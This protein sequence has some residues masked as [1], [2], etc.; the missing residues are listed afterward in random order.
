MRAFVYEYPEADLCMRMAKLWHRWVETKGLE[1]PRG[2]QGT[3][4]HIRE[5]VSIMPRIEEANTDYIAILLTPSPPPPLG[6]MP[7]PPAMGTT[8]S[9]EGSNS[10]TGQL[11][12]EHE[13]NRE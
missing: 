1:Y 3:W 11:Y 12:P 9:S 5:L 13:E 4:M 7:P 10:V 8:I 2:V 6:S